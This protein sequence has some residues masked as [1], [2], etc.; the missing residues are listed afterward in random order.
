MESIDSVLNEFKGKVSRA[1]DV[2]AKNIARLRTGRAN[3]Q[4]LDGVKVD[5]YGNQ[6]P[7]NQVATVSIPEPNLIMLKVWDRNA[8]SAVEKAI[9][10]SDIGVTPST[11]GDVIRV[12]FPPLTEEK[13]RDLIKQVKKMAEECKVEIRNFRRESNDKIKSLEK[14]S[15]ITEDDSKKAIERIQKETDNAI[16]KIDEIV[17]SKEKELLE[18]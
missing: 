8:V 7:I 17:S 1:I 5:Y 11:Q 10:A 13:R 18:I 2:Y 3:V 4:I 16:A 15:K 14:N 6:V 9:L 12:P